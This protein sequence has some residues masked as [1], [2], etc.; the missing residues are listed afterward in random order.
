MMKCEEL[1]SIFEKIGGE[2]VCN[3]KDNIGVLLPQNIKC[4]KLNNAKNL[5]LFVFK[6]AMY[7][8]IFTEKKL[9][10][11]EKAKKNTPLSKYEP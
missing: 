9:L 4:K 2:F 10:E 3:Y 7:P 5:E 8:S 11:S 1:F 6:L